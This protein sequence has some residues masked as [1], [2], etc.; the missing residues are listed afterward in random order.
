MGGG[1]ADGG[2]GGGAFPFRW[3]SA[4]ASAVPSPLACFCSIYDLIKSEFS[5][6]WSS[7][8]PI[9]RSSS[10]SPRQDGSTESSGDGL[11]GGAAG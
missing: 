7:V 1:G 5:A 8:M 2:G 9:C 3:S 4:G 11:L 10:S 6:I